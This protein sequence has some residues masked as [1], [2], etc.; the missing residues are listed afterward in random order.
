MNQIATGRRSDL[1]AERNFLLDSITDLDREHAA[2]DIDDADYAQLRS[3]YVRRAALSLRAL[4]E[5]DDRVEPDEESK[6]TT[7]SGWRRFRRYLGRRRVRIVL[8][9]LAVV[10]LLA[11]IGLFAAHLAGVRLPGESATGTITVSTADAVN[12]DLAEASIYANSGQ[13][14]TAVAFYEAALQKDPTQEVALTYAGWLTRLSGLNAHSAT[15]VRDGDAY[16]AA[17]ARLHPGY[18]DG[19]GLY[20]IAAYEDDHDVAVAEAAFNRCA[21]DKPGTVLLDAVAPVAKTV[22]S[23]AKVPLPKIFSLG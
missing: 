3:D 6:S 19:E 16:L 5:L 20:G 10:F 17:A 9:T 12:Q 13:P 15:T 2:G 18:P 11:A 14:Q 7:T 4:E 22:F 1:E 8:G 21:K 23:R